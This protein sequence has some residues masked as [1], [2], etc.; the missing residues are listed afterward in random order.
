[1]ISTNGLRKLANNSISPVSLMRLME[2]KDV[3]EL[4]KDYDRDEIVVEEKLDGWKV[5]VIKDGEVRLY[6]R[7]GEDKTE[8]F[9][10]IVKLLEWMPD[11]TLMEGE[12]VYWRRMAYW[13]C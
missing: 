1:M 7:R 4:L 10:Q 11:K 3:D 2:I 8:N 12:L 9:P 13:G 6:T 5:Q